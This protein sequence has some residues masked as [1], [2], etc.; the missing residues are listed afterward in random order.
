MNEISMTSDH[1]D[2]AVEHLA[3]TPTVIESESLTTNQ[4][5]LQ[6]PVS[7]SPVYRT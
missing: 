6:Q 4:D 7:V 5:R 1:P 3:C 2:G